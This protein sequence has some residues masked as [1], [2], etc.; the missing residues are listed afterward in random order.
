VAEGVN[1]AEIKVFMG[2]NGIVR[3]AY[4]GHIEERDVWLPR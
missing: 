2:E 4:I 1:I 3:S